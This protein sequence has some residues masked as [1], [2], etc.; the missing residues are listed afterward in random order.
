[1]NKTTTLCIGFWLAATTLLAQ[2]P[3]AA[4][5][6]PANQQQRANAFTDF[7]NEYGY[8]EVS[9]GGYPQ[10]SGFIW[11]GQASGGYRFNEKT[12]IGISTAV[13]G[14]TDFFNRW[15]WGLGVQMRHK[16]WEHLVAKIEGGYVLKQHVFDNKQERAMIYQADLSKPFYGKA[17]LHWQFKNGLLLGLSATQTLDMFF[18]RIHSADKS[19]IDLWRINA[20]AIQIG[21]ALDGV[22]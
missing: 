9:G 3:T 13:W 5:A 20:V 1:M 8:C 12:A 17:D 19:S 21:F 22:E 15:A 11:Q 10:F 7:I 6:N 16:M 18:K 4:H 2:N 14:R